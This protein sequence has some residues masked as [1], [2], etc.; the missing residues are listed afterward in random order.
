[1]QIMLRTALCISMSR[2]T[3]SRES[4]MTVVSGAA[5]VAKIAADHG[6]HPDALIGPSRDPHVCRARAR[7]MKALHEDKGWSIRRI[8]ALFGGRS[9]G[10]VHKVLSVHKTRQESVRLYVEHSD[11]AYEVEAQMRRL[12]GVNITLQDRKSVV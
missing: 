9:P 1:M 8:G 4:D 10:T 3:V 11:L 6:Y 2:V 12:C 7:A 5:I